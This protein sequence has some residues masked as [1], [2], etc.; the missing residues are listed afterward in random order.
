MKNNLKW[1]IFIT[2]IAFIITVFFSFFSQI[3]LEDV[4]ILIGI[5]VILIFILIGVIFDIIG[6][7]VQASDETPFHAMASK[8]LKRAK[9][10]KKMLKNA[11]KVSSF[12][13][14]VI[15]D[16]CNIISGSASLFVSSEIAIKYSFNVTVTTLVL[17]SLVAAFTIGG[18][19]MGKKIAF[20][21]SEYIVD[22]VT[23]FLN[24]FSK[25]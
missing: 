13:N 4:G 19:A 10:A 24:K 23:H 14:D 12:C 8:K 9:S 22:K 16:I 17:T 7:A 1:I 11:D 18:K 2:L 6:V 5:I 21:K 3:I 25:K 15:G 20:N